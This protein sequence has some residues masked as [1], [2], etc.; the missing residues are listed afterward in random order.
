MEWKGERTGRK[1]F[2]AVGNAVQRLILQGLGIIWNLKA[3]HVSEA[4]FLE[5][6]LG[7]LHYLQYTKSY[8][9]QHD[10]ILSF[11]KSF[12]VLREAYKKVEGIIRSQ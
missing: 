12:L 6:R 5:I 8:W 9:L 4:L 1:E 2:Q 10:I 3:A 7:A 11:W